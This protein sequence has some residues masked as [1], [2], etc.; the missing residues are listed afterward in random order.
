MRSMKSKADE[1]EV[2]KLVVTQ[3]KE[4]RALKV[5]IENKNERVIE[6]VSDLFPVLDDKDKEKEL[7]I[8]QIDRSLENALDEMEREIIKKKYLGT[9][10]EKDINIY[11]DLGLSKDQYYNHKKDAIE[12]IAKALGII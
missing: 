7:I 5:A 4:Y 6:G 2:R 3:L 11:L 10:R 1:K 9:Y 12:L 8:R